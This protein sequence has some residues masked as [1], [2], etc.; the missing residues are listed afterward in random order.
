MPN[1]PLFSRMAV[2]APA[3]IGVDS[4]S[5]PSKLAAVTVATQN[6]VTLAADSGPANTNCR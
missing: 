5:L 2:K 3:A 6:K 1:V 4:V